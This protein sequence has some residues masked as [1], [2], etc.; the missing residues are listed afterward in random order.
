M[1]NWQWL[2]IAD[3]G[4]GRRND[5]DDINL[6]EHESLL[7]AL[8]ADPARPVLDGPIVAARYERATLRI[9]WVLREHHGDNGWDYRAFVATDQSLFSYK[10]WKKTLGLVTKVSHGVLRGCIPYGD[11]ANDPSKLTDCLRE[12][13]IINLNKEGGGTHVNWDCFLPRVAKY[14]QIVARQI[15]CLAPHI[16]ICL[17]HTHS[18]RRQHPSYCQPPYYRQL[19]AWHHTSVYIWMCFI[20]ISEQ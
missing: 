18:C 16:V 5:V 7:D 19:Q 11:W 1:V 2:L 12:I 20:R 3:K 10:D 13:A 14:E 8:R 6:V 17:E 9:L 15:E 4:F